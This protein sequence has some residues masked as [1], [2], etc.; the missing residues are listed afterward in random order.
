M[1]QQKQIITPS[2]S[3]WTLKGF[4]E[5]QISCKYYLYGQELRGT[6]CLEAMIMGTQ[7]WFSSTQPG[8]LEEGT[9]SS[10]STKTPSGSQQPCGTLTSEQSTPWAGPSPCQFWVGAFSVFSR[11]VAAKQTLAFKCPCSSPW[12]PPRALWQSSGAAR[13]IENSAG[14]CP[15][16]KQEILRF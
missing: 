5:V 14:P 9:F 6:V 7:S 8:D 4:G 15:V 3:W 13:T 16:Y 2:T 11:A 1:L 10:F 12:V